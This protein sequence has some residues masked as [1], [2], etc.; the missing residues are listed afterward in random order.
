[1]SGA[2]YA[3][4]LPLARNVSRYTQH[5]HTQRGGGGGGGFHGAEDLLVGRM[6]AQSAAATIARSPHFYHHYACLQERAA[7]C[8]ARHRQFNKQR[9]SQKLL[10]EAPRDPLQAACDCMTWREAGSRLDGRAYCDLHTG[11]DPASVSAPPAAF[12][13][14][15]SCEL[16]PL[17]GYRNKGACF[18]PQQQHVESS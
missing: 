4:S 14:A 17:I 5:R 13:C 7:P 1:M 18:A 8:A 16:V 10:C 15:D 11:T 12:V 2:I 6:V 3:L 9:A